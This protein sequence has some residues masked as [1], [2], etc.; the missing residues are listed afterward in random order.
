MVLLAQEY[1]RAS[2]TALKRL[3]EANERM[4]DALNRVAQIDRTATLRQA[5]AEA[6]R[7]VAPEARRMLVKNY[8][9]SPLGVKSGKLLRAVGESAFFV[10]MTKKGAKWFARLPGGREDSYKDGNFYAAAASHMYGSTRGAKLRADHTTGKKELS[11]AAAGNL[12][13]KKSELK[14]F[15]KK[16]NIKKSSGMTYVEPKE[17]FFLTGSDIAR[18]KARVMDIVSKAIDG[19]IA[20]AA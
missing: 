17:F 13:E 11:R 18:L 16:R 14:K 8:G 6:S 10:S 7:E 19:I 12:R 9:S 4:M 15:M 20:K 1:G 3:D 2:E 5:F